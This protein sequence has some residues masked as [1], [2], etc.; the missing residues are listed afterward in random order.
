MEQLEQDPSTHY[1]KAI[2][3]DSSHWYQILIRQRTQIENVTE[4][5]II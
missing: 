2:E 5:N 1:Q 3:L 4:E